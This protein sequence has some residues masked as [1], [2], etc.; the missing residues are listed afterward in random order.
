MRR[1]GDAI[2]APTSSPSARARQG[3]GWPRS[4]LGSSPARSIATSCLAKVFH[5]KGL[6]QKGPD[7]LRASHWRLLLSDPGIKRLQRGGL[8]A[9]SYESTLAGGRWPPTFL[10]YHGLTLH[11]NRVSTEASRGEADTSPP[12]LTRAKED[13]NPNDPG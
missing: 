3:G 9:D 8:Q 4:G 5:A 12:A 6:R 13:G 2:A 7:C 1:M 11:E 10:C